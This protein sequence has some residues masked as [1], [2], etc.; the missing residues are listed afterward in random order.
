MAVLVAFGTGT[1][2]PA[3]ASQPGG[4]ISIEVV[5]AQDEG[6]VNFAP[7]YRGR[8]ADARVV[9]EITNDD[10]LDVLIRF[11]RCT[12][13]Q[14]YFG[15]GPIDT[16]HYLRPPTQTPRPG[17]TPDT[18]GT[19]QKISGILEVRETDHVRRP[20]WGFTVEVAY[21]NANTAMMEVLDR[22][23]T[24]SHGR[25]LL[26]F[27]TPPGHT[28]G[29]YTITYHV[30]NSYVW[31]YHP[32][33]TG[34]SRQV[35]I[36]AQSADL[37][38]QDQWLNGDNSDLR[39][40][41]EIMRAAGFMLQRF[42]SL[43]SS[44]ISPPLIGSSIAV[45]YPNDGR[46]G[47][48]TLTVQNTTV[49]WSCSHGGQV[50]LTAEH[51]LSRQTIFH[52]LAHEMHAKYW[53]GYTGWCGNKHELCSPGNGS[54]A[55]VEGYANFVSLWVPCG[56][57]T[58]CYIVSPGASVKF[59]GED[60]NCRY[61]GYNERDEAWV[62][63]TFWDLFDTN[64]DGLDNFSVDATA[65][66][67]HEIFLL[68]GPVGGTACDQSPDISFWNGRYRSGLSATDAKAVDNVFLQNGTY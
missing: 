51:A 16:N 23:A 53:Q 61:H 31:L 57:A 4:T 21:W 68:N 9:L 40:V 14:V 60:P 63:A 67:V 38:L 19:L 3:M 28:S 36:Q 39:G 13:E 1:V 6:D 44:T 58:P 62:A 46:T 59:D 56:Q 26:R 48:C 15:P 37:V 47:L 12:Q 34:Y 65:Q 11:P 50:D 25:F 54:Q 49:P 27:F 17:P 64:A 29:N 32:G 20:A 5:S 24:D 30:G 22:I 52:E 10:E 8:Q 18:G 33:G 43:G 41:G 35:T 66:R 7:E 45:I 55:L 2:H 42:Q